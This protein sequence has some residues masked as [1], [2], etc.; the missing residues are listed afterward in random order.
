[1]RIIDLD[2]WSRKEHYLFFKRMDYPHYHIGTDL[3]IT[4]FLGKVKQQNLAFSFTMTYAVTTVMNTVEAFRYRI[5][6]EQV[7]LHDKIHP[8]FSY[9]AP[10]AEYFK[11]VTVDWVEPVSAFVK[12]A[13]EKAIAQQ[14]Y[15]VR[16]DMEGRDDLIYIS[17]I[18]WVSFTHLSHTISFNKSDAVPRLSWGKY[19]ER[20]GKVLLP[21]NVQAHHAFV[22]GNHMG[23]YINKM[24]EYLDDF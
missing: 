11:M 6:G 12:Q 5:R 20:D 9:L 22:D 4:H 3:D 17:S 24:Q 14:K 23:E 21:F 10:G 13:K 19:Y 8:S 15:F 1:M 7:V 16:E 2:T 18:P